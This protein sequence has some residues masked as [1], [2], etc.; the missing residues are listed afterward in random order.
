MLESIQQEGLAFAE[1]SN[2]VQEEDAEER[3]YD[4]MH[5]EEYRIHDDM[6]D[7]IAF[8]A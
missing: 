8:L 3:Y 7:P 2:D 4:E 6:T 1:E 5:E